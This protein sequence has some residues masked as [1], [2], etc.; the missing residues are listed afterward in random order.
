MS[1]LIEIQTGI[2]F[3]P[4]KPW[5]EQSEECIAFGESIIQDA[6]QNGNFDPD[7]VIDSF[8]SGIGTIVHRPKLLAVTRTTDTGTFRMAV[9]YHWVH[10]PEDAD[11]EN[12]KNAFGAQLA[13]TE[14]NV[15]KI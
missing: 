14:I 11:W 12:T 6:R 7:T 4:E 1:Q 5:Y 15:Q 9:Q 3:D 2:F 10:N 13:P 8:D